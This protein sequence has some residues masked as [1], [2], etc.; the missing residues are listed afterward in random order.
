MSRRDVHWAAD[1]AESSLI[2]SFLSKVA[3]V[4]TLAEPSASLRLLK[5]TWRVSLK[6]GLPAEGTLPDDAP[7][8][9]CG[10]ASTSRME[11]ARK[12]C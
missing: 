5:H 11:G 6:A 12:V 7:M 8:S 1:T 9:G 4:P 3:L 10:V 2:S